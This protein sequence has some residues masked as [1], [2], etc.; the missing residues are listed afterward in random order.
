MAKDV[1]G[2]QK[3]VEKPAARTKQVPKVRGETRDSGAV[4]VTK[5]GAGKPVAVIQR[6]YEVSQQFL[7]EVRT[8]MKKV[9][10]PSRKETLASTGVVL[11]IVFFISVY[12][13]LVDFVLSRLLGLILR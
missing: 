2:D 5:E 8:E 6:G 12:L 9:T 1:S 7:R 3:A 11:I 4:N 10:W 13:G